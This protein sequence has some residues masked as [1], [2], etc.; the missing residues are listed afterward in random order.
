MVIK[1]DAPLIFNKDFKDF[2]LKKRGQVTIFIIIA[3]VIVFAI[4]IFFFFRGKTIETQI[5]AY[6]EPVYS[7]FLFCIEE[8]TLI[9]TNLIGSQGGYIY[10]PEFEPGSSYMPFSSQLNFLGSS[11]PYWYYV[12]GNNIQREKVPTKEMMESHLEDFIEEKIKSCNY[13]QYKTQGFQISWED[14][15]SRVNI[16]DDRI[17]VILNMNLNI[18]LGNESFTSSNHRV[19]V[20]SELGSLYN[21]AKR[22]YEEQQ[23]TL[24]LEDYAIDILRNYAPVDGAEVTCSPLIWNADDIFNELQEAIE[25]NTQA[26]TNQGSDND[27]FFVDLPVKNEVRFLNSKTWPHNFEVTPTEGN[28][29]ISTPVGN[30]PGLGILGFCYAPYH[31]VYDMK[32]PVLVQIYSGGEMFQFPLAVIIRG[33]N[34]REPIEGAVAYP[35]IIPEL[36]QHKNTEI[37]VDVKDFN[38]NPI[39]ADISFDCFANTCFIGQTS[40][41]G[42]L[43]SDF[44]QCVNGFVSA[45]APGFKD[46]KYLLSTVSAGN[47]EILMERMYTKE[48]QLMLDGT[49]FNGNALIYFISNDSTKT[50]VYPEQRAVEL[51]AGQ[52]EVQVHIFRDAEINFGEMVTEQCIEV[53]RSGILGFVGLKKKNCFEVTIPEQ[54]ISQS[55]AGG[56]KQN[57]YISESELA[58]LNHIKINVGSFPIPNDINQIQY[59][60]LLFDERGLDIII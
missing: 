22:V 45:K 16:Q 29:L 18:A 7:N 49:N 25:A 36:C 53:P 58:S 21:S 35:G 39:G 19:V 43:L 30:Q 11:V 44:P 14:P 37:L 5:P 2:F 20:N 6:A 41:S 38:G 10:L 3:I 55:L 52:Y 40:N 54:I 12:S 4:L 8:A 34:P 9:G 24:F 13:N 28:L 56:G 60:Y 50:I 27:Y 47:I 48:I 26:L 23:K 17:E 51:S 15:S 32:Y 42:V 33:N 59:N 57:Y 31:Y 1:R 46:A